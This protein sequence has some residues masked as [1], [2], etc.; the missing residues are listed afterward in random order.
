[1]PNSKSFTGH[2]VGHAS[3]RVLYPAL[4]FG[5]SGALLSALIWLLG[6]LSILAFQ[7]CNGA[8]FGELCVTLEALCVFCVV[9]SV[10]PWFHKGFTESMRGYIHPGT[11]T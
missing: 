2:C 9:C 6:I 4:R 7:P 10:Q 3:L 1:M 5:V 11:Y 8:I